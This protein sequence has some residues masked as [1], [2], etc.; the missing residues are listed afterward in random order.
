MS[1]NGTQRTIAFTKP[2]S[3]FDPSGHSQLEAESSALSGAPKKATSPLGH[4][5]F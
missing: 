3:A 1:A 4:T 2:M 5:L